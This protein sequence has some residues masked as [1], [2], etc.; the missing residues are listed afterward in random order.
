M[1]SQ[2]DP[3]VNNQYT[4]V[5][6]V[7][8]SVS[9]VSWGAIFAGAAAAASL[10]LILLILGAS[11]GLSS[12][13]PWTDNGVSAKT[14]GVSSILWIT[15]TSL[16]AS[17]LGGYIAGRLRTKWISVQGDETYFRD[18]AH[19]FLAWAT[20]TLLTVALLT[21]TIGNIISGGVQASAATVGGALQGAIVQTQSQASAPSSELRPSKADTTRDYFLD[22]LFR[23]D[24]NS[25]TASVTG[26]GETPTLEVAR[27]FSNAIVQQSLP[28]EDVRYVGSLIAQRNGIT[29]Q[30]AEKRV[31]DTFNQFQ[32]RIRDAEMEIKA[33][34]DETRKAAAYTSLW[35]FISLLIGAF[36][37]SLTA[38]FGGRQRDL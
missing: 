19:G 26:N 12:V 4:N 34:A 8:A 37:A 1:I 16:F 17:G 23:R 18:T 20:A 27:I 32:A 31:T 24:I 2:L 30:D 36:I 9:A 10:S 3:T 28:T 35:L 6:N 13:S 33:A 14:F 11:L 22:T 29:Q 38:I 21:S 15:L 25:S 5:G 7:N